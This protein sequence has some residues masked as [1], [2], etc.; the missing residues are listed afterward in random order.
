M[1]LIRSILCKESSDLQLLVANL[2]TQKTELLSENKE[3]KIKEAQLL[4]QLEKPQRPSV[5]YSMPFQNLITELKEWGI[6]WMCK[7]QYRPDRKVLYTNKEEWN[8]IV[9]FLVSPAD[10]YVAE[11]SDCDDYGKMAS[12]KTAIDFG[13]NGCMECWGDSPLGRHGFNLLIVGTEHC[14]QYRL[15]EPNAGFL[16]AGELFPISQNGYH[17][18]SWK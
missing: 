4:K 2:K 13:L 3:L 1:C 5:V 15:M 10:R 11:G 17:P 18:D 6:E 14:R 8:K 12:A 7:T 9:P 16:F